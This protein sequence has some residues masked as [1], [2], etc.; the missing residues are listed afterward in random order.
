MKLHRYHINI[1]CPEWTREAILEFSKGLKGTKLS[2]SFH[3][4]NKIAAMKRKYKNRTKQ[5]L[6]TLDVSNELFLDYVF[7]FYASNKHIIKKVCYRLPM[8][9]LDYDLTLVISS[10][11]K[12]VT[13][14]LSNDFEFPRVIKPELY[15]RNI[16]E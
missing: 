5:I 8:K 9:D 2:N 4:S 10:S 12:I 7:E 13:V 3:A 11:G 15:E 1:Y 6:K 14:Y 16:K